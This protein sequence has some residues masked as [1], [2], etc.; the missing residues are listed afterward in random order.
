MKMS[1]SSSWVEKAVEQNFMDICQCLAWQTDKIIEVKPRFQ[2]HS[3]EQDNLKC[4]WDW[5]N[6]LWCTYTQDDHAHYTTYQH[7]SIKVADKVDSSVAIKFT[8][9]DEFLKW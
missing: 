2:N 7:Q 6:W 1:T 8:K 3:Y 4:E 5:H 9:I